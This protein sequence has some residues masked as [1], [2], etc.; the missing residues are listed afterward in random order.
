MSEIVYSS[1]ILPAFCDNGSCVIFNLAMPWAANYKKCGNKN[2]S[3]LVRHFCAL[4]RGPHSLVICFL[5][6][7]ALKPCPL[8]INWKQRSYEKD[9]DRTIMKREYKDVK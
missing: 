7:A 4:C 8:A 6:R 3:H 9:L 2:K 5:L 1:G